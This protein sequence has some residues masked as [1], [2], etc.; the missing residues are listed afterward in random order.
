MHRFILSQLHKTLKWCVMQPKIC[1]STKFPDMISSRTSAATSAVS[2]AG[3]RARRQNL[4]Q[5]RQC[6]EQF[7][8]GTVVCPRCNRINDRSPVILGLKFFAVVLFVCT[9][10]WVVQVAGKF[11]GSPVSEG[12]S[13]PKFSAPATSGEPDVRF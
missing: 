10:I 11:D 6:S 4:I 12:P 2:L 3:D 13:L 9:V 7:A 1:R 8:K 5:C